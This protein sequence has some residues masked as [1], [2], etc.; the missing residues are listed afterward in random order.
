I[1]FAYAINGEIN[2]A[3]VYNNKKLFRA[4]WSK[5]LDAA[6]TE[7]VTECDADRHFTAMKPEDIKAFF[8]TAVSGYVNE[9]RVW[10]STRVKTYT[11]PTTVLFETLDL[12]ADSVWIHKSFINK[13]TEKIVVP[14][15]NT[16]HENQQQ[17]QPYRTR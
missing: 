12:D 9:H 8:E 16:S 1:G 11:T 10:K 15:D 2:S 3:E 14:L 6:V 13:G 7:A 5:L 4:L 17:V